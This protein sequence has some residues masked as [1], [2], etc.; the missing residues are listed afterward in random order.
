MKAKVFADLCFDESFNLTGAEDYDFSRRVMLQGFV[1]AITG[2]AKAT[3]H[4]ARQTFAN[5]FQTQRQTSYVL[6]HRK[7]DGALATTARFL[8]KGI[9]KTAK[10]II[11]CTAG[12]I[13]GKKVLQ[14]GIKNIMADTEIIYGTI[15]HGNFQNT[16]K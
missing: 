12:I 2:K 6:S 8:P 5:H 16:P 9:I 1:C 4:S 3:A 10:G 7:T 15:T 13:L 14:R 11:Y